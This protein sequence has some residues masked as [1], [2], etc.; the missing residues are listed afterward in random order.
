MIFVT[1]GSMF[2]FDRLVSAIDDVA[3][4]F[5]GQNFMA[6]IGA[7]R[8]SPRN[9]RFVRSLDSTSF[10]RTV[11]EARLIVAH[12]GMGSIITALQARKPIVVMPRDQGLG[13]VTSDH[14]FATA[15]RLQ[16]KPGVFVA[17]RELDLV[18]CLAEALNVKVNPEPVLSPSLELLTSRLRS[19]IDRA[20]VAAR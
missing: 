8:Y 6:Q 15:R 17:M 20:E 11:E 2:P 18:D 13:E 12:A 5:S 9:I 3:P 19:F 7:G 4:N 14:Q 1:V 10:A 16:G